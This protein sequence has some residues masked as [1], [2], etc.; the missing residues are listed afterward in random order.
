LDKINKIIIATSKVDKARPLRKE[1]C[2][3]RRLRNFFKAVY[4]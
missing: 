2:A 4:A 3:K 1:V